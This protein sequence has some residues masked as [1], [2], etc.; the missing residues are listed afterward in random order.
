[1]TDR[2][3]ASD[4]DKTM[5]YVLKNIS[6][7][8]WI[9][10]TAGGLATLGLLAAMGFPIAPGYCLFTALLFIAL[11]YLGSGWAL[12]R[13]VFFRIQDCLKDAAAQ[14]CATHIGE[15]EASFRKAVVLFDSFMVS[16]FLRRR[17]APDLA[18]R[19]AHFHMASAAKHPEAEIFAK[20][21]LWTHPEDAEIARHWLQNALL[22]ENASPE[23]LALADRIAAAQRD[24]PAIQDLMVQVYLAWRRTDYAALQ[25][26]QRS[27]HEPGSHADETICRLADLFVQEGRADEWALEAYL[28]AYRRAPDQSDYLA[29]LS[30][31]L[32]RIPETEM[33]ANLLAASRQALRPIDSETIRKRQASFHQTAAPVVAED[34]QIKM[35]VHQ[36]IQAI[37]YT[38]GRIITGVVES[39]AAALAGWSKASIDFCRRSENTRRGARWMAGAAVAVIAI[40]LAIGIGLHIYGTRTPPAPDSTPQPRMATSGR[41]TIQIASFSGQ[42]HAVELAD[43]LKRLGYPAYWGESRISNEK[44][45][46]FVRIS[47]FESKEAAKDFGESLKSNGVIDHFYV[48][49]YISK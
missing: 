49:N 16:P 3:R 36:H 6:I 26:Y 2:L 46:Y 7:R 27:L 10:V 30:A 41:Y 34:A 38:V 22:A 40:I 9:A 44:T 15:A 5:V 35:R 11:A 45:W 43:K 14:E 48:A 39:G 20:S 24:N 1:L 8:I 42:D 37:A 18:G 28:E 31:C 4:I 29:G 21:Y 32:E 25:T 33:N 47:R 17:L 19:I 13:F 12:D 23:D